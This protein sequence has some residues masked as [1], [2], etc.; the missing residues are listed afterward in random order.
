MK[1]FPTPGL[2]SMNLTCSF[3]NSI[4]S[5]PFKGFE[6]SSSDFDLLKKI[7]G[8]KLD[9]PVDPARLAEVIGKYVHGTGTGK[10]GVYKFTNKIN[11]FCY[12][13]SSVSL[14]NRLST[15]YLGPKLGNRVI[16]TA[17]KD[18]GLDKFYLELY[19]I[20][21][22]IEERIL[23]DFT[24]GVDRKQ[25]FKIFSL[26]LEQIHL[27]IFN[28]EYNVLKVAG[29]PAGLKRTPE[30]MLPSFIKSSKVTY[31]YDQKNKELVYASQTRGELAELVPTGINIGKYLYGKNRFYLDRFFVSDHPLSEDIYATNL[32][33][34]AD[35]LTYVKELS[36]D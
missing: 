29:S 8:I 32:R 18:S 6:L 5:G 13:G 31:L 11:G 7:K 23:R 14:A 22:E 33:S 17:I 25:Q 30:S 20:P 28:P 34:K 9:L 12:I 19:L 27:L 26:A 35:L 16:D 1:D 21:R 36:V 3:I 2:A 24:T 10:A 4:L 15:G